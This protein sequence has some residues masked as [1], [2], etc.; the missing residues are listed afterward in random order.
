MVFLH[1]ANHDMPKIW[2]FVENIPDRDFK[3]VRLDLQ[4]LTQCLQFVETSVNISIYDYSFHAV[5]YTE[6]E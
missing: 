4:R 3:I 2:A 6:K 5:K 1:I